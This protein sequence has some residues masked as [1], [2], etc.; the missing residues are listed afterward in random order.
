PFY[1]GWFLYL[2]Y[3]SIVAWEN[4]LAD[5]KHDP[6]QPLA[7]A[8][9]CR[10]AVIIDHSKDQ[11]WLVADSAKRLKK[12]QTIIASHCQ[13]TIKKARGLTV[14]ADDVSVYT[15]NVKKIKGYIKQGDVYQVN[16]A[17]KWQVHSYEKIKA[18]ALYQ[19]LSENNPA[20]FAGLLQSKNFAVISS[21]PE[22]LVRVSDSMVESRP[23]AGTRPRHVDQQKDQELI[24]ELINHPKEQA[25]HIMLIDLERNDLGRVCEIGTVKVDEFMSVESYAKVHHI[26]S[27]IKGKLAKNTTFYDVIK[28]TFPG[29]T[30]T[31]C[32]KIRC[33]Q[34]IDKLE[35]YARGAYTGSMGYISDDGRMDLNILIRTFTLVNNQLSFHAGAGIVHDSIAEKEAEESLHKAQAL[36]NS[37]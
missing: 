17:R 8:I 36:I 11:Y 30:I 5:I 29:G 7:L 31:G 35:N 21:S 15:E 13:Q 1:A 37:L 28:A 3:A 34:I 27:N 2:S 32:P 26:V 20:P 19:S 9:R 23:I 25:E 10:S 16:L 24:Q 22:R 6:Q 18:L 14:Q 12:L 4:V 33:M